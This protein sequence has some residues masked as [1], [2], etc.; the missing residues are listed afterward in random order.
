[1]KYSLIFLSKNY[2]HL[3][4][5]SLLS[6]KVKSSSW[7]LEKRMFFKFKFFIELNLQFANRSRQFKIIQNF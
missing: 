6:F 7:N 2:N 4:F 1:M 5:M 3:F